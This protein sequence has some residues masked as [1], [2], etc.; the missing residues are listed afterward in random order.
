MNVLVVGESEADELALR[1]LIA[2]IVGDPTTY[3]SGPSLRRRSRGLGAVYKSLESILYYAM[4]K[5][6]AEGLAII[7]D[8]DMD[9]PHDDSRNVACP[10]RRCNLEREIAKIRKRIRNPN[11]QFWVG[12]AMAVP[13]IESWC[14]VQRSKE[15]GEV[16]WQRMDNAARQSLHSRL[17]LMLYDT[18]RPDL[19]LEKRKVREAIEEI[20]AR[21]D[22]IELLSRKFPY[23]FGHFAE[24]LR[25]YRAQ[26]T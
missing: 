25:N 16:E 1:L 26:L 22:G 12:V 15:V 7:V 14:L 19:E 18:D 13:K 6:D 21:D 24:K 9:L 5:T 3:P 4:W 20:V 17:K 23:G 8:S 10:C 2:G 11:R